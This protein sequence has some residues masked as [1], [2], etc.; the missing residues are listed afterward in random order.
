MEVAVRGKKLEGTRRRAAR[1]EKL[2]FPELRLAFARKAGNKKEFEAVDGGKELVGAAQSPTADLLDGLRR[3][4]VDGNAFAMSG[5]ELRAHAAI[6]N[7]VRIP[8]ANYVISLALDQ[9]EV[10]GDD[11]ARHAP[12][13]VHI[14]HFPVAEIGDFFRS[15]VLAVVL[16][17]VVNAVSQL[18]AKEGAELL[19]P[20]LGN[21]PG[22]LG[23]NGT[24]KISKHGQGA[25]GYHGETRLTMAA[26]VEN[27]GEESMVG[28]SGD[29]S[30]LL[31][32]LA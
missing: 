8:V 2:L 4:Q 20:E 29:V 17:G 32:S 14:G 15:Q 13:T 21:V 18:F 10:V 26:S 23:L 27:R 30:D 25:E 11:L 31:R 1:M 7:D 16:N 6:V 3:G 12:E 19:P 24:A 28:N 5:G 22:G 9:L